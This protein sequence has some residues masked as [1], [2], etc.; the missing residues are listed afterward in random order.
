MSAPDRNSMIAWPDGRLD[1]IASVVETGL[2]A[3]GDAGYDDSSLLLIDSVQNPVPA[4]TGSEFIL[5]PL[6]LNAVASSAR[7]GQFVDGRCN[8]ILHRAW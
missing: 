2:S 5:M 6:K 1:V 7:R 4:D 3:L 8:S